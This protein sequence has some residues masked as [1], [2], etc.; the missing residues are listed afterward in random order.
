MRFNKNR[1]RL[2]LLGIALAVAIGC[3][4]GE[5]EI[6]TSL[7]VLDPESFAPEA[8]GRLEQR[9]EKA[10][11]NPRDA[12]ASGELGMLLHAVRRYD[13]AVQCYLRATEV[14]PETFRWRYYLAAALAEAGRHDEAVA[15]YHEA[16][17]IRGKYEPARLRLADSLLS[18]NQ[19]EES[20][21]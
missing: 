12:G 17:R 1:L 19:Y 10:E 5:P 6:T 20:R 7:P 3:G 2:G 14:A 18:M 4:P 11:S 9:L 15:A 21:Q 8:R 16:L 13:A